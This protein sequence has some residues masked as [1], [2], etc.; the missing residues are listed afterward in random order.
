M[1]H[2]RLSPLSAQFVDK[3]I[4]TLHDEESEK[5][6]LQHQVTPQGLESRRDYSWLQHPNTHTGPQCRAQ[7][8]QLHANNCLCTLPN[9]S[10]SRGSLL[11]LSAFSLDPSHCLH[12]TLPTLDSRTNHM[13]R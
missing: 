5:A 11:A 2:L 12:P 3:Q 10:P 4:Q 13:L 7:H 9:V 6:H 1:L 8:C